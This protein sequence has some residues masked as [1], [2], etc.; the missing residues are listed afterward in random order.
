M[1]QTSVSGVD[2][3][4]VMAYDA[5]LCRRIRRPAPPFRIL[6]RE[7]IRW[8]NIHPRRHGAASA[9]HA[10]QTPVEKAL[11]R[12]LK[13]EADHPVEAIRSVAA[14]APFCKART[15]VVEAAHVADCWPLNTTC[16]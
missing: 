11:A 15:S 3:P 7:A 2:T 9:F 14:G 16:A 1:P 13:L 4:G 10:A 12:I 5:S 6:D 8:L